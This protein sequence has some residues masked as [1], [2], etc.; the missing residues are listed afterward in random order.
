MANLLD[1]FPDVIINIVSV[2]DP[3]TI[4]NLAKVNRNFKSLLLQKLNEIG[5]VNGLLSIAALRGYTWIV[6]YMLTN[7]NHFSGFGF[8]KACQFGHL[9]TVI[10]FLDI[11][12]DY[13]GCLNNY[14]FDDLCCTTTHEIFYKVVTLKGINNIDLLHDKQSFLK[15]ACTNKNTPIFKMLIDID[16]NNNKQYNIHIND[17]ELFVIACKTNN[18]ELVDYLLDLQKDYGKIDIHTKDDMVL[19]EAASSNNIIL[20]K[21]IVGLCDFSTET[22]SKCFIIM[23][24]NGS[25]EGA[26][27]LLENQMQNIGKFNNIFE[28]ALCSSCENNHID[29]VLWLCQICILKLDRKL[30]IGYN[31][32]KAVSIASDK[33][34]RLLQ[35]ILY[36]MFLFY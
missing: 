33:D 30:D 15:K 34:F 1:L 21:K 23:C 27:F 16:K 2:C 13:S 19:L 35:N 36:Q 8:Q 28:E 12:Y 9:E 26:E 25:I 18:I 20:I 6:K 31:N 10:A 22:I 7:K 17:D 29:V 5:I 11:N 4:V 24:K 3:P 32:H 14:F